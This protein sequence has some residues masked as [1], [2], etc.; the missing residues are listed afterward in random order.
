MRIIMKIQIHSHTAE[1]DT[2]TDSDSD[3]HTQS[4]S[5]EEC[6][7]ASTLIA[8]LEDELIAFEPMFEKIE[9]HLK[10]VEKKVNE[11]RTHSFI[12]TSGPVE[13]WCNKK[14]LVGPF[15][16]EQWFQ[17]VLTD[18]VSTELETRTLN[19]GDKN[20]P[21]GSNKLSIFELLHTIPNYLR[22]SS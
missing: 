5:E 11:P 2:N 9:T 12:A 14:G 22:Y 1:S 6:H 7:S 16:L 21:W 15:T 13:V 19:F 17:A 20:I 18:V 10:A 4:D 3:K 8:H